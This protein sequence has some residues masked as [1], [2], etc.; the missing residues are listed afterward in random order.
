MGFKS[1]TFLLL[2]FSCDIMAVKGLS[3]TFTYGHHLNGFCIK[4][5]SYGSHLNIAFIGMGEQSQGRV[6]TPRR[7]SRVTK[8][9]SSTTLC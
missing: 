4:M 5:G 3:T 8:N 2:S 1:C 6:H 9:S 7:L